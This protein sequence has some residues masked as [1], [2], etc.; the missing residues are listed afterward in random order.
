MCES[1]ALREKII[2]EVLFDAR[3]DF[4]VLGLCGQTGSGVSTVAEILT[5]PFEEL[6]LPVPSDAGHGR[7]SESEYRI[8][9]RFGKRTL[10][11]L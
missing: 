9:Y 10:K 2:A 11:N 1:K 6:K 4:I 5:T 8:L 7:I 3:K